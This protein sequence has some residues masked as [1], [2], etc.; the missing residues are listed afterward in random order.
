MHRDGK[1]FWVSA[2]GVEWDTSDPPPGNCTQCG[3]RHWSH[4]PT[5]TCSGRVVKQAQPQATTSD[6][7][8][9]WDDALF[10]TMVSEFRQAAG[11][12]GLDAGP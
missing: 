6:K 2:T 9:A 7:V 11:G 10:E 3:Q 4:Q 5:A 12:G 1:E 8:D